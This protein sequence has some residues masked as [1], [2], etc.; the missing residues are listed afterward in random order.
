MSKVFT[1]TEGLE[2]LGAMST[3]GQGSVYKGR[4]MGPVLT[5]IKL[6]PT[7]ILNESED[8][9]NYRNFRNEVTKLQKVNEE[10]NPNVVKILSWGLTDSGSFPFIEMEYIEGPDLCEL[11]KDPHDKIFMLKEAIR[12]ADQLSSALAHCHRVGVKHGDVKSNNVKY[13]V[14]TGNYVLLDFGLAIMSEE[15][16]RTSI[17]HAGAVEFMAPEQHDGKMLLETDI[18]SYGIILYEL[19]TGE[20]PFP[21]SGAGDNARNA[22]MLAHIESK[23]PD[24]LTARRAAMPAAWSDEKKAQEMQ[25][26]QWLL[27]L[28]DKCL[29]KAPELRFQNGT[30][31]HDA[32]IRGSL[33]SAESHDFNGGLSNAALRSENER[34]HNLL[35]QYQQTG[36][37]PE[38]VAA[39]PVEDESRI[40]LSK[41][42]YYTLMVLIVVFMGFSVYATFLKKDGSTQQVKQDSVQNKPDTGKIDYG[43]KYPDEGQSKADTPVRLDTTVLRQQPTEPQ[44]TKPDS[45]STQPDTIMQQ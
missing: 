35:L 17:R 40:S 21:L 31:L 15:Q 13:N 2:N 32:I 4:R 9:R 42:Y 6:M 18:Y 7:P 1:I 23:V 12:V 3:G 45:T 24:L 38:P 27:K 41:P 39:E 33:A 8:D 10:P 29:Q 22:V 43:S 14:N 28:I 16:R 26:P 30:E 19:L 34:L 5:A 25:V 20:V 11:L 37:P 44:R 36:P